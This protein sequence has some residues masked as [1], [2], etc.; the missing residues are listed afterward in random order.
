MDFRLTQAS[1]KKLCRDLKLYSSAPALNDILHL[2]CKGIMKLENLDEYTGLKTLY[3]EQN[4]IMVIENL[5][6][7]T[8]L[9]CLYLGKN[10]IN[11]IGC[12]LSML[13]NLE[14]LDL[15]DNY[16]ECV[17]GLASL[18]SLR[19]LTLS[20]NKMRS[21]ADVQH[22]K[23]CSALVSLDLAN[24]KLAEPSVVDMVQH[25]PL[26]YLRLQGNPCVGQYRNYRKTLVAR[27]PGLNYLDDM[28]VF[29]K[30]RRLAVAFQEGGLEAERAE[31]ALLGREEEQQ[32][33]AHTRAFDEMVAR[34]RAN[35]P[36]PHDP[37][38]FRAVPPA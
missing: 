35:P 14:T 8:N 12:G 4:A 5:D 3:L 13:T 26:A 34:A 17:D 11:E 25:M 10:M 28:P 24:C 38:R 32:R 18:P 22:L 7:L 15:A 27:M 9:R 31:R 37:M 19:T 2:Q 6:A 16:I 33:E 30:D 29:P 20:G 1:L 23:S 21:L 36:P